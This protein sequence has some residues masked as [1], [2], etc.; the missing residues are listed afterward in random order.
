MS[1]WTRWL[2]IHLCLLTLVSIGLLAT[3][4]WRWSNT[5]LLLGPARNPAACL[6]ALKRGNQRFAT[7][8]RQF[9]HL[10]QGRITETSKGQ[11]PFATILACSDSRV[12]V[13]HLFD[14]GIGDLFV[15]RVAGNVCA[16]HESASI[17]YAVDHL[18]T[19]LV[20]I[21][22][23]T[24]CGAVTAVVEHEV[25]EGH[26]PHLSEHIVPAFREAQA[27]RPGESHTELID[28]TVRIHVRREVD[29]L[30]RLSPEIRSRVDAGK[31]KVVGAVYDLSTGTV[32]WFEDQP[33]PPATGP[34]PVASQARP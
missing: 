20:V 31:V 30:L 24:R 2:L 33:A 28:D 7:G 10:Q 12:A 26:I 29:E 27:A 17:E 14:V 16:D 34:Q 9:G 22:G 25:L 6:D 32:D 5:E 19:P 3:T 15:V 8:Q 21:L 4:W 11:V 1:R 13:E 18:N 23:H